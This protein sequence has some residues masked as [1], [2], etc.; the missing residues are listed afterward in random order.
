MTLLSIIVTD[1]KQT[2]CSSGIV[3]DIP[4]NIEDMILIDDGLRTS[5]IFISLDQAIF[6]V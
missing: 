6:L 1:E 4:G 2:T 3:S 5:Q